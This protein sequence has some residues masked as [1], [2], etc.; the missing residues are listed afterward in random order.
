MSERTAP[1]PSYH[2]GNLRE[3]LLDAV[4]EILLEKGVGGV[5]LREAARRAGVSHSA[6]A[7]HFG[8]K[9]GMLTAFAIRGFELFGASMRKAIA[10]ASDPIEQINA[11]GLA[12]IRFAVELRSKLVCVVFFGAFG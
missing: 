5:S 8:D 9:L 11:M 12:Y 6:P 4:G 2:H 3:A 7:H 10:S 1:K